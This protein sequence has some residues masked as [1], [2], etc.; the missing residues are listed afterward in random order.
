MIA[1]KACVTLSLIIPPTHVIHSSSS[2][3]LQPH[4]HSFLPTEHHN[5]VPLQPILSFSFPSSHFI[6][7]THLITY[8][9]LDLNLNLASSRNT[10][11]P[12]NQTPKFISAPLGGE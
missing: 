10:P 5:V 2:S 7:Y 11:T 9:S 8:H 1:D 12:T 3:V 4:C 6:F